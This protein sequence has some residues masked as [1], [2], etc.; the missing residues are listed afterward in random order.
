MAVE[1]TNL[2]LKPNLLQQINLLQQVNLLLV[3]TQIIPPGGVT[4][5][6]INP[7]SGADSGGT[8]ITIT[9]T[10]FLSGATVKLGTNLATS[11]VVVSATSITA[12]TPASS[13]GDTAVNV[14]VTN[15]G[16]S[17]GTLTNGF[18]YT[19]PAYPQ[20]GLGAVNAN[21]VVTIH[22]PLNVN[23]G[24]TVI[25]FCNTNS[26]TPTITD[27]GSTSNT[28]TL[29]TSISGYGFEYAFVCLSAG[30][31]ASIV[32]MSA[33]G[34]CMQ[35][36]TFT[37]VGAVGA[38]HATYNASGVTPTSDSVTTTQNASLV[39]AGAQSSNGPFVA[40]SGTILAQHSGGTVQGA[41]LSQQVATSGTPTTT[42]CASTGGACE[43][44]SVELQN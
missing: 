32:S 35:G 28:Y 39:L 44:I 34:F 10:G 22:L 41:I 8:P 6:A 16:G 13:T 12:V 20:P 31:V 33:G 30:F 9:G 15:S 38:H 43:I 14:T 1:T 2:L 37:G 24:D 40:T 23:V 17:T 19:A 42:S 11:V 3:P 18:T 7:T 25:I 27:N 29:V 36:A 21:A 26:G 4:V 5:L